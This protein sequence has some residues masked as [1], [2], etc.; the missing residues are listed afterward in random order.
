[1]PDHQDRRCIE[2]L[3]KLLGQRMELVVGLVQPLIPTPEGGAVVALRG[4]VCW[5]RVG[6]ASVGRPSHC[7][8]IT[9]VLQPWD[10]LVRCSSIAVAR[11]LRLHVGQ[12]ALCHAE[13]A[14]VLLLKSAVVEKQPWSTRW[15][16]RLRVTSVDSKFAEWLPVAAGQ[17]HTR[18]M[19]ALIA[20]PCPALHARHRKDTGII[21]ICQQTPSLVRCGGLHSSLEPGLVQ[22]VCLAIQCNFV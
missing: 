9:V 20:V 17:L 13:L 5:Y 4:S 15:A 12:P 8:L 2:R 3:A 1:M 19:L 6:R 18:C 22:V 11:G 14:A 10:G 7:R 21:D 16:Q